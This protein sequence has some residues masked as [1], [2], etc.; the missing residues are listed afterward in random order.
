MEQRSSSEKLSDSE[1][2]E[3]QEDK[4]FKNLNSTFKN[5]NKDGKVFKNLNKLSEPTI[6]EVHT[7]KKH[8]S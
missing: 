1:P 4:M 5:L 2:S 8:D 6:H 7:P 3:D